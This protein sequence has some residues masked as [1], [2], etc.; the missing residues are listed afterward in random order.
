MKW[1]VGEPLP[2]L[3]EHSQEILKEIGY[4]DGDVEQ[5]LRDGVIAQNVG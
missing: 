3:G 4:A 5:L 1:K 2:L